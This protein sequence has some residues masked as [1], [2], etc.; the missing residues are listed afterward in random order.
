MPK[1]IATILLLIFLFS[2]VVFSAKRSTC[3]TGKSC[4]GEYLWWSSLVDIPYYINTFNTPVTTTAAF[5]DAVDAAFKTWSDTKLVSFNKRGLLTGSNPDTNCHGLSQSACDLPDCLWDTVAGAQGYAKPTCLNFSHTIKYGNYTEAVNLISNV[6]SQWESYYGSGV[7]ALTLV[8]YNSASGEIF[9]SDLLINH[10]TPGSIDFDTGEDPTKFNLQAILTHEL[11]HLIGIA[12]PCTIPDSDENW[13]RCSETNGIYDEV[14]MYPQADPNDELSLLTL[15][16]DDLLALQM[17]C[18]DKRT[19]CAGDMYDQVTVKQ[20]GTCLRLDT[21]K[22]IQNNAFLIL[23]PPFFLI[24][25]RY[26][27][28]RRLS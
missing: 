15:K 9:E 24:F 5:E 17:V 2:S 20:G 19:K 10:S 6:N 25:F 28:R 8:W 21:G 3:E 12:H 11:G 13:Q 16:E 18:A 4:T 27:L 1:A 26:K 7:I 23:L 14:A 22:S